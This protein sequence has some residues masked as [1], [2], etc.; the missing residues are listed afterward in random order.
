MVD[1]IYFECDEC[2]G[3]SEYQFVLVRL[4]VMYRQCT[5]LL[6]V[7]VLGFSVSGPYR[8]LGGPNHF[9][10]SPNDCVALHISLAALVLNL[11]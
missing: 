5:T 8:N 3:W 10:I 4:N 7:S 6:V 1:F 9:P 2:E 11:H